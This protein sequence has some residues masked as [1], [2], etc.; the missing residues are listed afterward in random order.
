[1]HNLALGSNI[2][3]PLSIP[4]LVVEMICL[5]LLINGPFEI[6]AAG[7][8]PASQPEKIDPQ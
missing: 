4:E 7:I 8:S 5:V 1:M 2:P 3:N 6:R